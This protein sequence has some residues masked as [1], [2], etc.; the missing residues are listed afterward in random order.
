MEEIRE[1]HRL[2]PDDHKALMAERIRSRGMAAEAKGRYADALRSDQQLAELYGLNAPR[3]LSVEMPQTARERL[4]EVL[5]ILPADALAALARGDER[6][7]LGHTGA[8][9]LGAGDRDLEDPE[10]PED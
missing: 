2:S 7:P 6:V 1:F 3:R 9:A 4:V 5:A 10:N 8:I